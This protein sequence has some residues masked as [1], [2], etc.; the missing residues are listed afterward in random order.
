MRTRRRE[1]SWCWTSDYLSARLQI[2]IFS[3]LLIA[4][5]FEFMCIRPT[6]VPFGNLLML[7]W[8][9]LPAQFANYFHKFS[10]EMSYIMEFCCRQNEEWMSKNSCWDTIRYLPIYKGKSWKLREMA[11]HNPQFCLPCSALAPNWIKF[12]STILWMLRSLGVKPATKFVVPRMQYKFGSVCRSRK[13]FI[14][15]SFGARNSLT[16]S[17][18]RLPS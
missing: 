15:Q 4:I 18:P 7:F 6:T 3:I 2:D 10:P 11:F 1:G 12:E 5:E 16:F 14:I 8:C 17:L 13:Q 9:S